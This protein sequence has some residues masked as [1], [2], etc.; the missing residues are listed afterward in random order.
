MGAMSTRLGVVAIA[1]VASC[2]AKPDRPVER[3]EP[4]AAPQGDAACTPNAVVPGVIRLHGQILARRNRKPLANAV[5]QIE[6]G[7]GFAMAAPLDGSFEIDIATQGA[8]LGLA[9]T[10]SAD[11]AP[12]HRVY[13]QRALS[14]AREDVGAL[15]RS[16]DDVALLYR[17]VGRTRRDGRATI[18]VEVT[19]CAG[20]PFPGTTVTTEPTASVVYP[21]DATMTDSNGVAYVLDVQP[22]RTT[23][24]VA[25]GDPID[26]EACADEVVVVRALHHG[27]APRPNYAF[28]TMGTTPIDLYVD[29]EQLDSQCK[30]AAQVLGAGNNFTVWA[31]FAGGKA[32]DV[33]KDSRGWVRPDGKP[34]ARSLEELGLGGVLYPLRID[35][36]GQPV[37]AGELAFTATRADFN[38]WPPFD[39]DGF[40]TNA[41]A[42]I[43]V[44]HVDAGRPAWTEATTVACNTPVHLY[45]FEYGNAF[46]IAPIPIE[47]RRRAFVT[48]GLFTPGG[49]RDAADAR[50]QADGDAL[51]GTF[52]AFLA[53][54]TESARERFDP[55]ANGPWVRL[56]GVVLSYDL[57]SFDAPLALSPSGAY[58]S[59]PVWFGAATP[60]ALGT[61]TCGDWTDPQPTTVTGDPARSSMDAFAQQAGVS[62]GA[63]QRLYCLEL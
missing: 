44:G 56:D 63:S 61:S 29:I 20:R 47:G 50:C 22:G 5:I 37:P 53:T 11:G 16:E 4:I 2:Y 46:D 3:C 60:D 18:I 33:L 27:T 38:Y 15:I 25:G 28:V 39:C 8:P 57:A 24:Q 43:G 13:H 58:V 51:G 30:A 34:F 42:M 52:K 54:T 55:A 7:G 35:Q 36:N 14:A 31:A 59:D 9:A 62:C 10:I 17:E 19:D 32:A 6:P 41:T 26:V 23:V 45:C 40:S 49:G 48:D 1:L 12:A 21:N